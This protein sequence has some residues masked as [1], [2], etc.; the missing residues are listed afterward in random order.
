MA[1][2]AKHVHIAQ[3]WTQIPTPYFCVGQESKSESVP[4]ICL[5]QCKG[6][7][8]NG[9]NAVLCWFLSITLNISKV[10][11]TLRVNGLLVLLLLWRVDPSSVDIFPGITFRIAHYAVIVSPRIY[12]S[13]L[14]G[15]NPG[16]SS[17]YGRSLD[18]TTATTFIKQ[19]D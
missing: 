16:L 9:F 15:D 2:K 18:I 3:T 13:R 12:L 11:L 5:Q 7:I 17:N 14:G 10:T 1:T 6:A 4:K 8:K 19:H